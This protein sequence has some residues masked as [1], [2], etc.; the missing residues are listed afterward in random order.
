[1]TGRLGNAKHLSESRLDANVVQQRRPRD[2]DI[3]KVVT[4]WDVFTHGL[5]E[6]EILRMLAEQNVQSE[7]GCPFVTSEPDV[8]RNPMWPAAHV[9]HQA[10]KPAEI[11]EI[12]SVLPNVVADIGVRLLSVRDDEVPDQLLE[13]GPLVRS[14]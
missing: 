8:R 14:V 12:E 10:G 13:R 11:A 3:E 4:K 5:E 7:I 2:G 9:Q 6:I 1:M